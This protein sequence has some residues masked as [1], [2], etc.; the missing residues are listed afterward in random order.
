MNTGETD[1]RYV[2]PDEI[3]VTIEDVVSRPGI[4]GLEARYYP[5]IAVRFK[6]YNK[7]IV[8][9]VS[10]DRILFSLQ[11][12]VSPTTWEIKDCSC[13]KPIEIE[14]QKDGELEARISVP[15]VLIK[16]IDDFVRSQNPRDIKFSVLGKLFYNSEVQTLSKK[17]INPE[18]TKPRNYWDEDIVRPILGD[19]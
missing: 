10:I 16:T 8:G 3:N 11:I 19:R 12:K 1:G 7:S 17:T 4:T 9:S 15:Y 18:L 5:E 6:V 13:L 14:D 2:R